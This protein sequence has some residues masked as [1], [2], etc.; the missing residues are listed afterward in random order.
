M[1]KN[2]IQKKL[3]KYVV[4]YLKAHPD[5]KV[6]CVAGSVGK[7]STK[8]AIATV[9]SQQYR[10]HMH[11][12]NHNTEMSVP[13]ALLGIEYPGEIRSPLAWLSVFRAAKQKIK[14]PADVDIIIQELGTDKPGDIPSFGRYLRP[15]VGVITAVT[16]EHME[17][18]GTIDAVAAEELSLAN[19]SQVVVINRDDIDGK[20]AQLLTNPNIDTY[21]TSGVAEY[22]FVDEDFTLEGGHKGYFTNPEFQDNIHATLQVLGEHNVR[23]V[24]G[25]VAVAIRFGMDPAAIVRGVEMIRPVPGRMNVLKGANGSTIID[26]TYNSS[27]AAARMAIQTLVNL[28]A[29]QHI[30]IL[31]SMNELG[32]SSQYEHEQIGRMCTPELLD[33]VVTIGDE[34]AKY[35]A[36]V[37]QANGCTVKSFPDA[38]SAGAYIHQYIE[39]GAVILAKG[40]E[41]GIFVE[42]AIKVILHSIDD[43]AKLVRQ[44]PAWLE[45]KSQ[46][47]AKF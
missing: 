25:A 1:F 11:E 4:K 31:G 47:F 17:F 24:V 14:Q 30:A 21:G 29:P 34:A 41:G 32:A 37:A 19:F 35:L 39:P 15:D 2:L 44:T 18:F 12:G 22:S 8:T 26:D 28:P 6:I 33:W 43:N 23:P 45:A 5:V 36:P 16:P 13:L 10:V 27:P 42:E 38:L 9:L 20:Y 3:E 46:F 40:S 7:T